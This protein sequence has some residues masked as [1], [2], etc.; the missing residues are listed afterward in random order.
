MV[1]S[2]WEW[3]L[4]DERRRGQGGEV[5]RNG[6]LRMKGERGGVNLI[7]ISNKTNKLT[8]IDKNLLKL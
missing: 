2:G 4:K 5:I 6:G 7:D 1:G 8:F 3:G